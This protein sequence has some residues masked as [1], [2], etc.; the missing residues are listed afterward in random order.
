MPGIMVGIDGSRSGQQAKRV[1]APHVQEG[2][3]VQ[4]TLVGA[5]VTMVPADQI[6]TASR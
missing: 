2:D 3:S 5:A 1:R 4:G 6:M